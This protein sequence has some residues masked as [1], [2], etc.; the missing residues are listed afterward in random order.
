MKKYRI[1]AAATL[2]VLPSMLYSSIGYSTSELPAID[3]GASRLGQQN[4][5]VENGSGC[6]G[7]CGFIG[8]NPVIAAVFGRV[9]QFRRERIDSC[10][11]FMRHLRQFDTRSG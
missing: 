8:A 5:P 11:Q 10:L 3:P 1:F 2:I 4:C 6:T 7:P 9:D